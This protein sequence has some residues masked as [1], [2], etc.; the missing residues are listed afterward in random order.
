MCPRRFGCM[1]LVATAQEDSHKLLRGLGNVVLI[2][3]F[4]CALLRPRHDAG[5]LLFGLGQ[6]AFTLLQRALG[7]FDYLWHGHA[8]LLDQAIT[9]ALAHQQAACQRHA[10]AAAQKAI[11]LIYEL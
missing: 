2:D 3:H 9:V 7:L 6:D 11:Q 4:G 5:R 8:H 10:P 1:D